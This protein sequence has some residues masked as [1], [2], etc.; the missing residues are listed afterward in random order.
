MWGLVEGDPSPKHRHIFNYCLS[1]C[2]W[3]MSAA[4]CTPL[5]WK[6]DFQL[7]DSTYGVALGG[8]CW[9]SRFSSS[10]MMCGWLG[11]GHLGWPWWDSQPWQMIALKFS[12]FYSFILWA[13]SNKQT[14][15]RTGRYLVFA[16]SAWWVPQRTEE[17]VRSLSA[18]LPHGMKS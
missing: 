13:W 7:G 14:G 1:D 3:Q 17:D 4:S 12:V 11:I 8:V 9:R 6:A 2:G 5:V 10:W 18:K 16:P 15:V